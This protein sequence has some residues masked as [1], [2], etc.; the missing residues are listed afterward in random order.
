MARPLAVLLS[1]LVLGG[2]AAAQPP[3]EED[4]PGETSGEGTAG[5]ETAGEETAGG[6]TAAGERT[7]DPAA[8]PEDATADVPPAA[9]SGDRPGEE[10]EQAGE[11]AGGSVLVEDGPGSLLGLRAGFAHQPDQWIAGP[12]LTLRGIGL[13]IVELDA[14][15][16]AGLAVEH[17][18]LRIATHLRLALPLGSFRLHALLGPAVIAYEPRGRFREWCDKLQLACGGAGVGVEAGLGIGYGPLELEVHLG[19]GEL[20]LLTTTLSAAVRL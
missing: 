10:P 11:A 12:H 8:P 7:A 14:A 4:A 18:T 16:V 1:T 13:R 15:V 3:A 6:E 19:S 2:S 20:P 17:Y 5:E 9:G